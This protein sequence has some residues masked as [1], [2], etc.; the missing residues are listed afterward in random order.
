MAHIRAASRG[1]RLA[2]FI[3]LRPRRTNMT[4]LE[5]LEERRHAAA[6]AT[7]QWLSLLREME[8]QGDTNGSRYEQYFEAYLQAK[9]LEK[10][11]DLELF[12]LREGLTD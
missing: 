1:R 2:S 8:L 12:N 6:D 9:Q 4:E 10:R 7:R 3:G 5:R 11:V